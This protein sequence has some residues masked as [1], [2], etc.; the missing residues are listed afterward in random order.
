MKRRIRCCES[1]IWPS[2]FNPAHDRLIEAKPEAINAGC[3]PVQKMAEMRRLLERSMSWL[4][5]FKEP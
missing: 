4:T 3:L 2:L 5:H 1:C